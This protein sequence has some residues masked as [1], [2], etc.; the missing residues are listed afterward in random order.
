MGKGFVKFHEGAY[1]FFMLTSIKGFEVEVKRV[2]DRFLAK[3]IDIPMCSFGDT[4]KEVLDNLEEYLER[5]YAKI[6]L[7]D[8]LSPEWQR[9][10]ERMA[11][12]ENKL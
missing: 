12:Q 6:R 9:F 8:N 2:G 4:S 7:T 5:V 10:K 11:N 3:P 1:S